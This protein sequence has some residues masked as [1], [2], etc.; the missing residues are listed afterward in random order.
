[1]TS[2]LRGV[3]VSWLKRFSFQKRVDAQVFGRGEMNPRQRVISCKIMQVFVFLSHQSGWNGPVRISISPLPW[4][5][6]G[7]YIIYF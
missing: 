1:M 3:H 2:S 5:F 6:Q 7:V 4:F